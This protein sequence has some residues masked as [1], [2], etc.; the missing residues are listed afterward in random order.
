MYTLQYVAV[1]DVKPAEYVWL[2][3][4]GDDAIT[5]RSLYSK[6]MHDWVIAMPERSQINIYAGAGA[7]NPANF[8]PIEHVPPKE[9][10][11]FGIFCWT[12]EI[13]TI[14]DPTS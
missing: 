14:S 8:C 13:M 6:Q 1:S 11:D 5:V 4:R 12:R 10:S 7:S 2:L 9:L 3:N